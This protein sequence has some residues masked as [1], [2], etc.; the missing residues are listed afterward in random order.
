MAVTVFLSHNLPKG[1]VKIETGKS[2]TMSA[3][4]P[5]HLN[6]QTFATVS[7]NLYTSM[8]L[9]TLMA[10]VP[11]SMAESTSNTRSLQPEIR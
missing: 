1:I 4:L 3:S 10:S 9:M 8:L 5:F 11:L 6:G 2:D 7:Y